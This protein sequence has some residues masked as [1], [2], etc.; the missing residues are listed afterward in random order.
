MNLDRAEALATR[1][2]ARLA[3]HCERIEIAGSIRRRREWVNDIDLVI[4]PRAGERETIQ[5]QIRSGCGV[6]VE[7]PQN[8]IYRMPPKPNSGGYEW[9]QLDIFFARPA[10]QDLLGS[11]PGNFG[12]LLVCRTGSK[13]H[14]I[15]LVEHAKRQGLLWKP[16]AGVFDGDRCLA[17]EEEAD[18][19]ATLDLPFI[20]PLKR[21]R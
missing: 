10:Q 20:P 9:I 17:S 8:C 18:I 16:Y 3:P 12:T 21:E 1:V 6:E 5:A 7:G 15:W 11:T 19:F 4:L 2:K 14:N 13:E